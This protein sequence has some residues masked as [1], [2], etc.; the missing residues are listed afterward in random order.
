MNN[1]VIHRQLPAL[2]VNDKDPH[3]T[4]TVVER[5]LDPPQQVILVQDR[6]ALN[7][8]TSLRHS[9]Q[10]AALSDIQ[11]TVLLEDGP[12]HVLNHNARAGVGLEA[13]LLVQFLCEEVDTKVAVLAGVLGGSDA[14]DLAGPALE[15]HEV[16][17]ADVVARDGDRVRRHAAVDVAD[18][19]TH[20]GPAGCGDGDFA[21]FD[22]DFL[23]AVAVVVMVVVAAVDGVQD[24]VG[25][26]LDSVAE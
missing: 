11:D 13:T 8:V 5:A 7:N 15:D 16:A 19:L 4:T 26:A 9:N 25:G 24:A 17:N 18:G 3:A 20:L 22:D 6:Q 10:S 14:D 21:V 2:V 23:D 12:K 1:L